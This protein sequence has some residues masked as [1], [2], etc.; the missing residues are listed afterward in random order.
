MEGIT[1]MDGDQLFII[2]EKRG[3]PIF[4]EVDLTRKPAEIKESDIETLF[5]KARRTDRTN[6]EEWLPPYFDDVPIGPATYAIRRMLFLKAQ[7]LKDTVQNP[8]QEAWKIVAPVGIQLI[9][10]VMD[11]RKND[12]TENEIET[13]LEE[14]RIW[15]KE[16][17]TAQ[18]TG[19]WFAR[20]VTSS[21][22]EDVQ[23]FIREFDTLQ[24]YVNFITAQNYSLEQELKI[25]ERELQRV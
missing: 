5:A 13:K 15:N 19:D 1:E 3:T 24:D 9:E 20:T 12:W 8:L 21:S 22:L 6:L 2:K 11:I 18:E 23:G 25:A 16:I 10:F 4:S 17:R 7:E 14:I